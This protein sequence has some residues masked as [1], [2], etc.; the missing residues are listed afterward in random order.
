MA[1]KAVYDV[2]GRK[3]L[4][5]VTILNEPFILP[6]QANEGSRFFRPYGLQNDERGRSSGAVSHQYITKSLK[7]YSRSKS[8]ERICYG[9]GYDI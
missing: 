1:I 7:E 8:P 4:F 2:L 5:Y 6:C 9:S 3:P